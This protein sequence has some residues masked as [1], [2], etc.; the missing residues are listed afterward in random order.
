[1]QKALS[2]RVD[3]FIGN[4]SPYDGLSPLYELL[5]HLR[6]QIR[7]A[8]F[9]PARFHTLLA[10][11]S[12]QKPYHWEEPAAWLNEGESLR[13]CAS[14]REAI[15]ACLELERLGREDEVLILTTTEGPYISSCVTDTIEPVCAWSRQLTRRTKM[16]L[17]IHE[18]GFPCETAILTECKARGITVVEDCAYALGSRMEGAAVGCF[19]DY[20]IY[21]LPKSLPIPFGGVLASKRVIDDVRLP[22]ELPDAYARLLVSLLHKAIPFEVSS[23]NSR[24]ENWQW[25]AESLRPL[26]VEPYFPLLPAVVPGVYVM[27]LEAAVDA[28]KLKRHLVDEGVESTQY[29]GMGGFY[30]PVHQHLTEYDKRYILYHMTKSLAED[31]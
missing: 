28:A 12:D 7:I 16:A 14:G 11:Q 6:P 25:F 2:K 10:V 26:G 8:P 24:R 21:S 1:V 22:K 17:I 29:Y 30:V 4:S 19:G 15:A 9:T 13:F 20:A 5:P 3:L 31:D 23:N 27:R 18:F